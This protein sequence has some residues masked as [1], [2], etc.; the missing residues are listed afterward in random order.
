MSAPLMQSH[1]EDVAR[2]LMHDDVLGRAHQQGESVSLPVTDD[3]EVDL[4]LR[5]EADNLALDV[6]RDDMRASLGNPDL[7]RKVGQMR[8]RG[9]DQHGLCAHHLRPDGFGR[10]SGQNRHGFDY[11]NDLELRVERCRQ[12]PGAQRD[13]ERIRSQIEGQEQMSIHRHGGQFSP[14]N[15]R[16]RMTAINAHDDSDS[17][18]NRISLLR[19]V[20]AYDQHRKKRP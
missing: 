3:D 20:G 18:S 5:G 7:A 15:A 8:L 11:M 16:L 2:R 9:L 14:A 1:G 10:Y 4:A 6:A 19:G 13:L 12:R 17:M